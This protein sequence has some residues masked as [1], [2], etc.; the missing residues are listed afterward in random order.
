MQIIRYDHPGRLPMSGKI[1][2]DDADHGVAMQRALIRMKCRAECET[3]NRP[4]K[5]RKSVEKH[6][7]RRAFG[8][9]G[10]QD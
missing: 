5:V 7:L 8:G 4:P 3:V 6:R 9:N 1:I 2:L 10:L